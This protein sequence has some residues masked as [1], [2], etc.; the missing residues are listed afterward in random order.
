MYGRNYGPIPLSIFHRTLIR[1][2]KRYSRSQ[3]IEKAHVQ[4]G[5]EGM[6]LGLVPLAN[7]GILMNRLAKFSYQGGFSHFISFC[8]SQKLKQCQ[9]QR[10]RFQQNKYHT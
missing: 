5:I 9:F 3:R 4:V 6:L 7:H 2:H 10:P 1:E 8:R